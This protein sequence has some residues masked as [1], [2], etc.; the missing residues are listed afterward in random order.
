M[1]DDILPYIVLS[2]RDP[3][4][5]KDI[6]KRLGIWLSDESTRAACRDVRTITVKLYLEQLISYGILKQQGNEYVRIA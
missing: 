2:M 3:F 1:A 4:T 5:Y 6:E